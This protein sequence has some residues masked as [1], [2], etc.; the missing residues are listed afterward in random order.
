MMDKVFYLLNIGAF[1]VCVGLSLIAPFYPSFA[2]NLGVSKSMIGII[3]AAYPI[4][5]AIGS[6]I[7][8]KY[9]KLNNRILILHI[10]NLVQGL[11]LFG[12]ASLPYLDEDLFIPFSLIFRSI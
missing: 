6:L 9:M 2:E 4:G 11:S 12:F 1:I 7:I 8:G 5:N 10:G 3:F